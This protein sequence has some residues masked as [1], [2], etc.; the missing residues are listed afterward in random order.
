MQSLPSTEVWATQDNPPPPS[1]KVYCT[2]I[3]Y[4]ATTIAG[5]SGGSSSA[6]GAS[7]GDALSAEQDNS[8]SEE[9]CDNIIDPNVKARCESIPITGGVYEVRIRD[10][11]ARFR[12]RGCGQHADAAEYLLDHYRFMWF[13]YIPTPDYP[14]GVGRRGGWVSI[15]DWVLRYSPDQQ[16]DFYVAHELDHYLGIDGGDGNMH[17]GNNPLMTANA[18]RCSQGP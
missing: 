2:D 8:Y 5:S 4:C 10:T 12:N 3:Y 9:S 14:G 13:P 17:T 1:Q 16:L 15:S 7:G 11:I 6:P 18:T